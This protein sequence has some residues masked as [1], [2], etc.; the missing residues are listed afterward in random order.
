MYITDPRGPSPRRII[1]KAEV[2]KIS[3]F[4]VVEDKEAMMA[5]YTT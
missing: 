3:K 4:V 5:L 2:E 1:Q